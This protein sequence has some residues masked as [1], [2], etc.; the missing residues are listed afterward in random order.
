MNTRTSVRPERYDSR[1]L[2]V[3]DFGVPDFGAYHTASAPDRDV[4][5]QR[6]IRAI[7]FFEPRLKD[8]RLGVE[9]KADDEK[10]LRMLIDGVIVVESIRMPVSFLTVFQ[11]KT[12]TV[13]IYENR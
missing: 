13:E 6:M 7:S 10:S 1:D 3:I 12:G 8:V 2:S 9:P 11:H 4:L 5:V